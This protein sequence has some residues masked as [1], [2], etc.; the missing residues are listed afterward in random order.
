MKTI[1]HIL[2]VTL[3]CTSTVALSEHIASTIFHEAR[4]GDKEAIRQRL[5][6]WENCSE[7]DQNGNTA[8]HIAAE[9]GHAEIVEM[10]T[11]PEE[12]SGWNWLCSY[13]QEPAKL[14]DKDEKNNE[15]N[16]PLHCSIAAG[17]R[18][19]TEQ[20]L[21]KNADTHI[22][23]D[24]EY[25]PVFMI[26]KNDDTRF[27]SLFT[28]HHCLN[29]K[30]KGDTLLHS[31]IKENK[32]RLTERLL[33]EPCLINE[34]D[35]EGKTIAT[36]ALN[37][38]NI[39]L[40]KKLIEKNINFNTPDSDGKR[41]IHHAAAKGKYK[42]LELFLE[43]KISH[44][45]AD[46]KGNTPLHDAAS[47]NNKKEL[48]LLLAYNADIKKCNDNGEDVFLIAVDKKHTDLV[49]YL[50]K[51]PDININIR[52][53]KG[54]TGFIRTIMAKDHVGTQQLYDLNANINLTDYDQE[55]ALHKAAALGD[56]MSTQLILNRN[57]TLLE[58]KNKYG[59][60][61][62]FVATKNG[63]SE[64]IQ[65]LLQKYRASANMP[66]ANGDVPF[67]LAVEKG[68][69]ITAK[70]LLDAGASVD[71][72]N[73]QGQSAIFIAAQKGQPHLIE[74]L[75]EQY[76]AP[77]NITDNNGDIPIFI[78][79]R[80]GYAAST[81]ALIKAKASLLT[82]DKNGQTILHIAAQQKDTT[83]LLDILQQP[84]KP[85]INALNNE[86]L[87]PLHCAAL[88]NNVAGMQ[89]LE[90]YGAHFNYVTPSGN[91]VAHSAIEKN[92]ID[93]LEYSIKKNPSLLDVRNK[94]NE[95]PFLFAC[96]VG[97]FECVKKLFDDNSSD[98]YFAQGIVPQAIDA[99]KRNG[100]WSV[101][102]FLDKQTAE[103]KTKCQKINSV[104]SD[105]ISIISE[106]NIS[107]NALTKNNPLRALIAPYRP[108]KPDYYSEEQLFH[109]TE[110]Q[111]TQ[112]Y[113]NYI[114]CKDIELQ[115]KIQ[116]TQE[117]NGIALQA[118][119]EAAQKERQRIEIENRLTQERIRL[120]LLEENR[121]R[122]LQEAQQRNAAIQAQKI[123][124]I[125]I[126]Q[127]Q[128]DAQKHKIAEQKEND[129]IIAE[130]ETLLK[131]ANDAKNKKD[132]ALA[133]QQAL[134]DQGAKVLAEKERTRQQQHTQALEG[135]HI[136]VNLRPS[137][138]PAEKTTVIYQCSTCEKKSSVKTIPC[139]T[140]NKR[141]CNACTKLNNDAGQCPNCWQ[142]IGKFTQKTQGECFL[143]VDN[144]CI[145]KTSGVTPIPCENCK[146]GSEHICKDCLN[147]WIK[148]NKKNNQANKCPYCTNHT[149]N[150]KIVKIILA[151]K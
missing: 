124:E 86:Q 56:K 50:S 103:R 151:Q 140:C 31:A 41:P 5:N 25:T 87:T 20:L 143:N 99:A 91:T 79:V 42:I 73:R 96:Q 69:K 120:E 76:H 75:T 35:S 9:Q 84:N 107:D 137:A 26:L 61:P 54:R 60:T 78:T 147:N 118:A 80:K 45:V 71:A 21:Q 17:Q 115:K 43:H 81:R 93:A 55:N 44:E 105:V 108:N 12:L 98:N 77:V 121:R 106:N 117:L 32:P 104:Y 39:S 11:T 29:Q 141:I 95:N 36:I 123:R 53:K 34:K 132:A 135:Q 13:F 46:N 1:N 131:E 125:E 3:F 47:N 144:I 133:V 70:T 101:Y 10:L 142:S 7:K 139:K 126:K 57:K 18:E 127:Q 72:R 129:R 22:R 63:C 90:Q 148:E 2:L 113:N 40:L 100:H 109:M 138:P 15:G 68:D 66:R 14:P 23:N 27:I 24:Q 92:A 146:V 102:N 110:N 82:K 59:E 134:L 88:T 65:M 128:I 33:D 8:L 6:N 30:Y 94:Q 116:F 67:L 149:L 48:D 114:Q 85:T 83:I 28:A 62:L 52:D 130:Q 38:D 145:E 122:E 112:V 97:S 37:T 74:M 51:K 49:E 58:T 4:T 16:T 150:P 64:F 119:K 89:L 19:T 111:R 136:P